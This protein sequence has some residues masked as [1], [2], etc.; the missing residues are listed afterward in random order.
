MTND[1]QND[2]ALVK[3]EDPVDLRVYT[4]VCLPEKG[5]DFSGQVYSKFLFFL[6]II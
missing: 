4:P 5:D 2:I 6:N 3:L 1:D